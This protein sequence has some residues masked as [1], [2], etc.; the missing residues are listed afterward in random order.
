[1]R[2]KFV[3]G[4]WKMNGSLAENQTRLTQLRQGLKKT[5][6]IDIAVFSSAPYLAQCKSLLSGSSIQWG[7]QNVSEYAH[8]AYTGELSTG[9]LQDF[10]CEYALVGHSERR[11][12]F[13]E[14]SDQVA[15]KF[16]Q[17]LAGNIVPVLCV[18]ETLQQ[19]EDGQTMNVIAAQLQAV[20]NLVGIQE[21]ARGVVAYE[22]VW[23]IG[24]GKTATPEQA[25][26]IHAAIRNLLALH[27][28]NT[29]GAMQ[30]LYGGSVK[31]NN[32]AAIF[33]QPDVD[34]ALVGGASLNAEDFIQI[35]C[36]AA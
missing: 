27:D 34:G 3:A 36:A 17:A 29:A 15:A 9:M 8:G 10:S 31:P 22:P 25:Q 32:A 7:A 35:C 6:D 14:S 28:E 21:F 23:A 11:E 19:R 16:A 18:G 33:A 24:T 4:N 20:L 12:I 5:V 1:M 13:A 2:R 30:I 26:E